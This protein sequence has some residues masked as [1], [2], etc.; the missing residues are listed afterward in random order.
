[1][2][3]TLPERGVVRFLCD[4]HLGDGSATDAFGAKDGLLVEVLEDC[5]R[6][7]DAVVFM[8]DAIDLPQAWRIG[9]VQRA[10]APVFEA[11]RRLCRR[12]EVWFVRGNHDWNVDY[13]R[14]LPGSRRCEVLRMGDARV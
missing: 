7:C 12:V 14:L 8:G 3:R 11:L 9:R 13:E 10:H 1:M 5:G 6:T 2:W 4:L